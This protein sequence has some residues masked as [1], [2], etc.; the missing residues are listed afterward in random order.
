MILITG[1]SGHIGRRVSELLAQQNARLRLMSRTPERTC[2]LADVESVPGDFQDTASLARAFAGIDKA[3]VVS[4]KAEP[5]ERARL[6]NDVFRAAASAGVKHIVYLSLKGASPDSIYPY[7]RDHYES[8]QFLAASG[9]PYTAVRGAFYMDMLFG[10]YDSHGVIRGPA[11]NGR[12]AFIAREDT[13]R[14]AAAAVLARPSGIIEVTGR[15]LLTLDD[16]SCRLSA[17]TGRALRY[18]NESAEEMANRLSRTLM[19]EWAQAAEVNW[20]QAIAAGEQASVTHGYQRLTAIEPLNIEQY[21]SAF[22]NVMK[23]VP[24]AA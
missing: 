6:H 4:G 14:A 19:P 22:P 2:K 21:C 1:A 7:C 13:A 8:E 16:V 17:V 5:G 9:V 12:G 18:E 23:E 11:G 24:A 15:E 10:K 20:F 3:L